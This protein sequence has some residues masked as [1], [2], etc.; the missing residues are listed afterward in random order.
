M[1][2]SPNLL[3]EQNL[4]MLA[5]T[6][7]F[8]N[9]DLSAEIPRMSLVKT[10]PKEAFPQAKD[11]EL[12]SSFLRNAV[13]A[14]LGLFA[15]MQFVTDSGGQ[16]Y[17]PTQHLLDF[18][19]DYERDPDAA[20]DFFAKGLENTRWAQA[21]LD[22]RPATRDDALT[23]IWQACELSSEL[24]EDER[25][26]VEMALELL[27]EF[28]VYQLGGGVSS[29]ER[30]EPIQPTHDA[31]EQ[32]QQY[33]EPH[34]AG[35]AWEYQDDPYRADNGGYEDDDRA[36]MYDDAGQFDD[37][38]T[39][40]DQSDNEQSFGAAGDFAADV[41]RDE[42]GWDPEQGGYDIRAEV[43]EAPQYANVG[44]EDETVLNREDHLF[45]TTA[46]Q[47]TPTDL[48]TDPSF[49]GFMGGTPLPAQST[50]GSATPINDVTPTEHRPRGLTRKITKITKGAVP[51]PD[52]L[53]E[54]DDV[55]P[56]SLSGAPS[57]APPDAPI[58]E[59]T[60]GTFGSSP[61]PPRTGDGSSMRITP[62]DLRPPQQHR[63]ADQPQEA[64]S[65]FGSASEQAT[66][67][68]K[69]KSRR[70]T[71]TMPASQDQTQGASHQSSEQP[72]DVSGATSKKVTPTGS[73]ERP[74]KSTSS[75]PKLVPR[76]QDSTAPGRPDRITDPHSV[77]KR[78]AQRLTGGDSQT[79]KRRRSDTPDSLPPAISVRNGE[80]DIRDPETI[81][82]IAKMT[83]EERENLEDTLEMLKRVSRNNEDNE[84]NT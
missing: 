43:G 10:I 68:P 8:V 54:P 25:L 60:S 48:T 71:S 45:G 12:V 52:A 30:R 51:P 32:M 2:P 1:L 64:G 69:Q 7:R 77:P 4:L 74:S 14:S 72:L 20:R 21:V 61:P 13:G 79:P 67:R 55:E 37:W 17:R 38:Q 46:E 5:N 42:S 29:V 80:I 6:A 70:I 11:A 28:G 39:G 82:T 27:V 36:L 16:K 35:E 15:A 41:G 73:R 56:S 19:S 40:A 33:E 65:G 26:Q 18:L 62:S 3:P 58:A 53:D 59:D 31:V 81:E 49:K 24:S 50:F 9:G 57:Y 34:G 63:A 47:D 66:P 83:P 22:A 23:I 84:D 44:A 78:G 76:T 75:R